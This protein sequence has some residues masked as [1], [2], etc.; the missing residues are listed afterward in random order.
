MSMQALNQLV[1]RSIIDPS[2]VESFSSGRIGSVLEEMDFSNDLREKM[3]K[4]AADTWGFLN[5]L[6]SIIIVASYKKNFKSSAYSLYRQMEHIREEIHE[7]VDIKYSIFG[8]I[9]AMGL[10]SYIKLASLNIGLIAFTL[11]ATI[12]FGLLIFR[13]F[14]YIGRG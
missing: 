10:F 11:L 9:T 12:W 2:I 6:D 13:T 1:A 5:S 7:E 14:I 8:I 4:L 3:A